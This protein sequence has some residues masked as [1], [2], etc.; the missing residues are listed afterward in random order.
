M[1]AREAFSGDYDVLVSDGFVGNVL[2]KT[3]EGAFNFAKSL[4]KRAAKGGLIAKIGAGMM[5]KSLKKSFESMDYDKIGG[6]PFLGAKEIVVKA[7]GASNAIAISS[8]I[9]L[10]ARLAEQNIIS[11][12]ESK[13]KA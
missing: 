5:K 13:L 1:E 2:L 11:K 7:H 9:A 3:A 4:I 8:A 6:S 10:A 12:I